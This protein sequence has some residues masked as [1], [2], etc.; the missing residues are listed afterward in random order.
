MAMEARKVVSK[1]KVDGVVAMVAD[2]AVEAMVVEDPEEEGLEVG[3]EVVEEDVQAEAGEVS[4]TDQVDPTRTILVD[5]VN[6]KLEI[7]KPKL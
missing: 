6:Q 2:H 1:E 4:D 5:G 3:A 7:L